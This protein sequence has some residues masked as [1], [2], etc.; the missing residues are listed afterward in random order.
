MDDWTGD[1]PGDAGDA[2]D[3]GNHQ[4][5]KFIHTRRLSANDDVV[6]T[7]DIFGQRDALN[8]ADGTRDV[9]RLADI[10]LDQDVRLYDHRDSFVAV[11]E[12][13]R[14]RQ[15]L[16]A[17]ARR[18]ASRYIVR[19]VDEPPGACE[20]PVAP[21]TSTQTLS[22][23]GEFALIETLTGGVSHAPG[24]LIGPGDDAAAI[25]ITGILLSSVDVLV[26]GV[27]FRRDWVEARDVGRRAVAVNVADIEAMGG[28]AVGMLAGFSAPG[29]LPVAWAREFADGLQ[30]ECAAAGVALLGGDVTRARDVTVAVTVLGVTDGVEPVR[31]SG[32][33]A[34]IDISDGL[35]ADLGHVAAASGVEID[36]HRNAFDVPEALHAVA[37]ATNTDPYSLILTGGEDH[38]LAA[39]F[40]A[41]AELPEG[42]FPIGS[43]GA[44]GADGPRVLVDGASWDSA[45]GFDHFRSVAQRR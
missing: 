37:A 28:R 24:V 19:C 12:A 45:G 6:R 40:S 27:H 32:A 11:T 26:E 21:Q 10:G 3:L 38:A 41:A 23:L 33:R 9:G 25:E 15:P 39:T 35:L 13:I 18:C 17:Y 43:V 34:M 20:M 29:D 36:L 22:E 2:L 5:A 8:G 7:R 4:L 31:R 44:V 1:C 14:F 16:A 30:T 42:W